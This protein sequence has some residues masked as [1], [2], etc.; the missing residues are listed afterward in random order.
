MQI[1]IALLTGVA[2]LVQLYVG[3]WIAKHVIMRCQQENK[4]IGRHETRAIPTYFPR[5]IPLLM[6]C[7]N[8]E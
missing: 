1:D 4:T 7:G 5:N 3:K 2:L 8:W 6:I